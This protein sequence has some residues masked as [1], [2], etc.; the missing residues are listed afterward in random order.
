MFTTE[1]YPPI[2]KLSLSLL[3]L[4]QQMTFFDFCLALFRFQGPK[5][6]SI[7][8]QNEDSFGE[9]Q[10]YF[11]SFNCLGGKEMYPHSFICLFAVVICTDLLQSPQKSPVSILKSKNL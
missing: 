10:K 5:H 8:H 6:G 2:F 9:L 4:S 1:I 11:I 7:Q 3:V